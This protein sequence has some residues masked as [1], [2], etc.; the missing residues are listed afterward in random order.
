M[1]YASEYDL[2]ARMAGIERDVRVAVLE[3]AVRRAMASGP[4]PRAASPGRSLAQGLR[5]RGL[6]VSVS[7][8][9]APP[10]NAPGVAPGS[11]GLGA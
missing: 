5:F 1:F 4:Q 9:W 10:A 3:G 6:R 8:K 2:A 11:C 7:V